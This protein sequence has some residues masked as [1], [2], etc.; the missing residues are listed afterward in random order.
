MNLLPGQTMTPR[1]NTDQRPGSAP[2]IRATGDSVT[3][4]FEVEGVDRDARLVIRCDPD[5]A[6]R[7]AIE[8]VGARQT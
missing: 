5:G 6:I 4:L 2:E 3:F 1:K 7:V 8:R